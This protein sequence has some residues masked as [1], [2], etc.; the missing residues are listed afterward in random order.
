MRDRF[1][2]RVVRTV[3]ALGYRAHP[4]LMTG[5]VLTSVIGGVTGGLTPLGIKWFVDGVAAVDRSLLVRGAAVLTVG[6]AGTFA[7]TTASV[8]MSLKLIGHVQLY[9]NARVASLAGTTTGV[10]HF[11]NPEY[12][13]ELDLLA[14]HAFALGW[15]PL[16]TVTVLRFTLQLVLGVGVLVAVDPL[17]AGL[18]A[19]A[20]IPLVLSR[21]AS[22][23]RERCDERLVER[24]RLLTELFQ[25]SA[26]APSGRELRVYGLGTELIRRYEATAAEVST[27]LARTQ[28]KALALSATGWGIYALALVV[29]VFYATLRAADGALTIGAAVL[30]MQVGRQTVAMVGAITNGV[31]QLFSM[32]RM[33]RR[34]HWLE[35]YA[36]DA[37]PRHTTLST[38]SALRN[39]IDLVG[40]SFRYPRTEPLVLR[41][42]DLHIPAGSTVALVGVNGAGK[43][44]LVKLLTAMYRPTDGQILV[45]GIDLADLDPDEWRRHVAAGFQDFVRFELVAQHSV[46]VGDLPSADDAAAVEAA[47]ARAGASAVI[48]QLPA[49]LHTPLGRSIGG[50]QEISGG[51]WQQLALGRAMMRDAPLLVVLDEPTASL[52][53]ATEHALFERYAE[54]ARRAGRANGAIT[55]L[56]SH[57]FSTVQMADVIVVIHDNGIAEIGSHA[58]LLELDGIYADLYRTQAAAYR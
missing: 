50:G 1:S 16:N 55:I 38:P 7:A 47:L 8:L 14:Q 37:R 5:T 3:M 54:A 6:A 51:Q 13:R 36:A 15:G 4:R 44:T 58:K 39:G 41:D 26:S 57:R 27:E 30:T 11:E 24:R 18:V 35:D 17:L 28:A 2:W 29:A 12:L 20:P 46:G 31:T 45:D 53:S 34:L 25:L 42:V 23:T 21:R 56:V 9:V 49:G 32:G 33:A 43:T 22:R 48:D 52:D 19:L 10:E 40:V